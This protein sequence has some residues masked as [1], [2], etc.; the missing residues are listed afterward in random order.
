MNRTLRIAF[1]LKNTYRVN[2]ILYALKQIPLI[3]KILPIS[4]YQVKGL[5][6]FANILTAIWEVIAA[7]FGKLLFFLLGI[8]LMI[9]LR[10]GEAGSQLFLHI[11]VCLTLIGAFGNTY[12]FNP[13][14]DKY[15]ALVL[16]RMDAKEYTLIHYA[17]FLIKLLVGYILFG[18][19]FG[20]M[21]GLTVLECL[22]L[23]LSA[24][25]I[26]S[27][28]IAYSLWKYKRTGIAAN[29]NKGGKLYWI[30]MCALLAGAY[31]LPCLNIML[32]QNILYILYE[33]IL[34]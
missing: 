16:M 32:P 19:I 9:V 20:S 26:K 21:F 2:S 29:E 12:V 33:A 4:L 27:T 5:K 14:R 8:V 34:P 28:M 13:T 23:P 22:L 6:V 18:Y 25:G 30:A 1:S 15:Y 17:Y 10:D 3:K 7:L 24:M 11:F 31:G